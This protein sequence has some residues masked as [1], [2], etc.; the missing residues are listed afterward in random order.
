[1]HGL[2]WPYLDLDAL[3]FL[4]QKL[5]LSVFSVCYLFL[6]NLRIIV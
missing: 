3:H 4:L 6:N 1:M 5:V 2:L